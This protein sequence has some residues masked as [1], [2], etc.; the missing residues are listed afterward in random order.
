[1]SHYRTIRIKNDHMIRIDR[2]DSDARAKRT[3]AHSV[4]WDGWGLA[5]DIHR[6][7]ASRRRSYQVVYCHAL[8]GDRNWGVRMHRDLAVLFK[9]TWG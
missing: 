2:T 8:S 9:L 5:D 4:T 1:M 6:W 3:G 7:F